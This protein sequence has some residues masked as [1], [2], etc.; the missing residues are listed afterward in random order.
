MPLILFT[1]IVAIVTLLTGSREEESSCAHEERHDADL[2]E[3]YPNEHG[4]CAYV[5]LQVHICV[6][7]TG[8]LDLA[9]DGAWCAKRRA[10]RHNLL[11]DARDAVAAEEATANEPHV[12]SVAAD[13][14][15]QS[16]AHGENGI[17][18]LADGAKLQHRVKVSGAVDE[19]V[20]FAQR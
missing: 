19:I 15:T 1:P 14:N 4:A 2:N 9:A 7:D 12:H 5:N 3:R 6:A 18:S 8:R 11:H 20:I 13:A 16:N 17:D 10:Q